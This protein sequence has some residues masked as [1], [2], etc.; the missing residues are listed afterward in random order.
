MTPAT[1]IHAR[2][3][4]FARAARAPGDQAAPSPLFR[5]M[6]VAG[7]APTLHVIVTA[8]PDAVDRGDLP[9]LTVLRK[10]LRV[11]ALLETVAALTRGPRP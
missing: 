6:A 1:P 2:P 10:P 4:G 9:H 3:V 7:D 11:E 5:P 8:T